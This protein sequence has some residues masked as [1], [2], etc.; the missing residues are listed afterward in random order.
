MSKKFLGKMLKFVKF[1][2]CPTL[3][4]T[5][6]FMCDQLIICPVQNCYKLL[7]CNLFTKNLFRHILLLASI[8]NGRVTV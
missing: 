1:P 5:S 3:F 4:H 2:S 6:H 8:S 7:N